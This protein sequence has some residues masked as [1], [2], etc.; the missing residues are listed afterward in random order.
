MSAAEIGPPGKPQRDTRGSASCD[1]IPTGRRKAYVARVTNPVKRA[2]QLSRY[3]LAQ[4]P[5]VTAPTPASPDNSERQQKVKR[6][7]IPHKGKPKNN[8]SHSRTGSIGHGMQN[9]VLLRPFERSGP[10]RGRFQNL[11][12]HAAGRA[13]RLLGDAPER[14]LGLPR[15][16]LGRQMP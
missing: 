6:E 11:R 8:I 15:G 9:S 4:I 10:Q 16:P 14:V 2:G 13:R 5:L 12:R 7:Y 3:S 1:E